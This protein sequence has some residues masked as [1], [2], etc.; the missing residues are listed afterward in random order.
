M[1]KFT[2]ITKQ[3]VQKLVQNFQNSDVDKVQELFSSKVA[4]TKSDGT[5]NRLTSLT[6]PKNKFSEISRISVIDLLFPPNIQKPVHDDKDRYKVHLGI[7]DE[8]QRVDILSFTDK[9][10]DSN[11]RFYA[12]ENHNIDFDFLIEREYGWYCDPNCFGVHHI[13]DLS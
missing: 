13:D 7:N 10:S 3:E 5:N 8:G 4:D 1:A 9:P 6:F 12:V 2:Q 11:A